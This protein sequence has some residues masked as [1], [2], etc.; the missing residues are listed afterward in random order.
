MSIP[1]VVA[2]NAKKGLALRS[3]HSRGGTSVGVARARDLKNQ[4][5]LSETTIKKIVSYFARHEVDKNAADFGSD[6]KPSAGYV[7][8]L[9]WGG[10]EGRVG[11]LR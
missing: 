1:K 8:W 6:D 7:A 3:K 9:L 5:Y 4:R 10:D 2:E 11:D